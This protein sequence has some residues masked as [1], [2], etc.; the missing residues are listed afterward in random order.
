MDARGKAPN[1]QVPAFLLM[2]LPTPRATG[3]WGK[4]GTG[5]LEGFPSAIPYGLEGRLVL[6]K[7]RGAKQGHPPNLAG[8]KGGEKFHPFLP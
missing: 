7:I 6:I 8:Q 5:H 1:R 2:G 4:G 3:C